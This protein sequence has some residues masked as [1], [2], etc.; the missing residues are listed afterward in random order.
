MRNSKLCHAALGLTQS[1]SFKSWRTEIA[2]TWIK[3]FNFANNP[4]LLQAKQTS[5]DLFENVFLDCKGQESLR[6][7]NPESKCFALIIPYGRILQSLTGQPEAS[8][9][10]CQFIFQSVTLTWSLPSLSHRSNVNP[11][12]ETKKHQ[13]FL[14]S[15]TN[16]SDLFK[17]TIWV[18][19][20]NIW[21]FQQ[22]AQNTH[23]APS[24][25]IQLVLCVWTSI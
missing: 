4:V 6:N 5:C 13:Q 8:S 20:S 18:T 1:S 12:T 22:L 7:N 25:T 15:R 23:T 21:N 16:P 2:S 3:A 14:V 24:A 17:W 19:C 10:I 11:T 9:C